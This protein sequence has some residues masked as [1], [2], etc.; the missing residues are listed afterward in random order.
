[1]RKPR[2]S[3]GHTQMDP[4]ISGASNNATTL[5]LATAPVN[6]NNNDI[7]GWRPVVPFPR[8][9]DEMRAA[10]YTA[11]EFD[12]SFGTDPDMLRSEAGARGISWCGA[13]Q[14]VDF[15]A[16]SPETP[17]LLDKI[18]LLR[19]IDCPNLIVADSLRLHRVAMAGRVPA[20]GS[21]SLTHKNV[22]LLASNLHRV[23]DLALEHGVHVRFHNHVGSWIEAPHELEGLMSQTDFSRVDLCF[24]TGHFAYGG[25]DAAAFIS[26]HHDRIGYLHIKDVDAEALQS[27]REQGLSFIDALRQYVFCPIGSGIANIPSI[28][29]VLS[30]HVYAGWVVAEQD[31]CRGDATTTARDNRLA[32]L[33]ELSHAD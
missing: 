26:A 28:M 8:I 16:D 21:G 2:S 25:G 30:H 10:G 19:D 1:M 17:E 14:W 24:D 27:A 5:R 13:Y 3:R 20:D 4:S 32:L 6:W 15:L 12:S 18:R 23:A 9:L 31:T 33:A 29:T 7:P 11:T 22:E